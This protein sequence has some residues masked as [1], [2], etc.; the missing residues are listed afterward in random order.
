MSVFK[1][2]NEG[3]AERK[4]GLQLLYFSRRLQPRR[5]ADFRDVATLR[6]EFLF[7]KLLLLSDLLDRL[8]L[9]LGALPVGTG[10]RRFF[11]RILTASRSERS[12]LK[13]CWRRWRRISDWRKVTD[14]LLLR[15]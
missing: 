15:T 10:K 7:E 6:G 14:P 12:L 4:S 3:R 1:Q 13:S 9:C 8:Q 5:S 11:R 2:I